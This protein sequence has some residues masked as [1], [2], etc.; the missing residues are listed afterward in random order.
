VADGK[1]TFRF[2]HRVYELVITGGAV[3]G[4]RRAVLEPSD[5][6]RG[7]PGSR[8]VVGDFQ[9]RAPVVVV[10]SGGIGANHDLA[11]QNWP[12]SLGI[13]RQSMITGVP[14]HVDGRMPAITENAGG[15]IVN[16]DRMWHCTEG[17]RN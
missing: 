5:A 4:V 11:R 2:R 9:L 6:A 3:T 7:K 10:T 16:P 13:P 17:R 1:V 15:R 14:A 8:T 12:A